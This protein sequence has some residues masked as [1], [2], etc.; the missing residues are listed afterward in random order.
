LFI[1]LYS[2]GQACLNPTLNTIGLREM[3][4]GK[5]RVG[6]GIIAMSRGLGETFGIVVISLLLERQAFINLSFM[7]PSQGSHLSGVLSYDVLSRLRQLMLQAGDYGAALQSQAHSYLSYTLL[8][9][10]V[11]RGYQDLFLLIAGAY[12]VMLLTAALFLRPAGRKA[13]LARPT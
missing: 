12:F 5:I 1:G 3:P 2:A 13:Q 6:S 9:E 7:T 8:N 11:T 10:A 4:E